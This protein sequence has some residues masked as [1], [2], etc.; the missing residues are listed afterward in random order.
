MLMDCLQEK[1]KMTGAR[2]AHS[3]GILLLGA[4]ILLLAICPSATAQSA[5]PETSLPNPNQLLQRAIANQ[6]KLADERERYSCR[7]SDQLTFTDPNGNPKKTTATVK[8]LFFVNGIPI[9]RL[10]AK[11]GKDLTPDEAKKQDDKVMKETVKYSNQSTATK[12]TD[13]VVQ[14]MQDFLS[15]M[16]LTNGRRRVENGRNVLDYN[17]VPNPKFQAKN[18][19]QRVAT[20][21][22]GTMELD[23]ATGVPID[24]NIKSVADL[25]IAGGLLANVHKGLWV[26]VHNHAEP[27]GVWLTDLAEGSGDMREALFLHPYLR[28]KQTTGSCQLYSATA[29]QE[30]Q[31][32]PVK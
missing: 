18:L 1:C 19:N 29:A 27:D 7:V 5:A 6:Q 15:A 13:K 24:L 12:E 32:K 22:Q 14:Q 23:E 8:E 20:V 3:I 11:D 16:V 9:E 28:F 26:H 2:L 21:M 17:I 30:G 25:K 4:G 10:L 31:E